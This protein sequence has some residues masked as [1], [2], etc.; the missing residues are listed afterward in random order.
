MPTSTRHHLLVGADGSVR[1]VLFRQKK[2]FSVTQRK[3]EFL[4]AA[5]ISARATSLVFTK[6]ALREMGTFNLLFLRILTGFI[7]L[8]FLFFKRLIH[9]KWSTAWRGMVLGTV[10]F[11][12]MS[13]EVTAAHSTP[14]ATISA[15]VNTAIIMVPLLNAV[16]LHRKPQRAD[17]LSAA[18]AVIGVILLNW[19]GQGLR[20]H[21]GELF[22]LLEAV[23]YACAIVLTD[24]FSHHE[25]DTLALG[26]IQIGTLGTL[27]LIASLLLEQ[28]HLPQQPI[29]WISILA[30]AVVCT[31]FGFTL[32]PV[33]QRHTNAEAAGLMCAVNPVVATACG[34]FVLHESIAALNLFGIVLIVG[35]LLLP[36]LRKGNGI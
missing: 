17:L 11:V 23:L 33:A 22:C 21:T 18:G 2:V 20:F 16:L 19:T 7:L 30:L 25:Q 35:S 36:H 13:L 1:P 31:G 12:I 24:R 5:I 9:I 14:A 34:I 8:F 15:L 32:Q 4:L 29:A 6:F 28:P 27:A 10:F 3:A 26:V